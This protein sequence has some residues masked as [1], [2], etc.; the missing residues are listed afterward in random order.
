MGVVILPC[1][2][3]D[4]DSDLIRI[5]PYTTEP[6]YD[7]WVLYHPNLRENAKIR[8]F[9]TFINE[10]LAKKRSLLE[11]EGVMQSMIAEE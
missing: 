11:G 10:R 9:V 4:T 8:T 6:K 3:G 2:V 1:F 5:P 7:L